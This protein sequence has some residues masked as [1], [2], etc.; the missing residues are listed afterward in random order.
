MAFIGLE[1]FC[2]GSFKYIKNPIRFVW[3]FLFKI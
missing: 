1:R 3:R 2:G